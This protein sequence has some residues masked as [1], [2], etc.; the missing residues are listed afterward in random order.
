M[1]PKDLDRVMALAASLKDAPHWTRENYL[2]ALD[3]NAV[4][5]RI[6]LVSEE[7]G[8]VAGLAVAS[9]I[10]PQAELEIIAVDAQFQRRSLA[11]RLFEELASK[12]RM[13]G[14]S[15]LVLE[16]RASNQAALGFYRRLGFVETGRRP[17]YYQAPAEDA[18]LMRLGL[19][20]FES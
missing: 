13:A 20:G 11:R 9:L 10:P 2:A 6:A 18:V 5:R 15:E 17:C 14:V 16:V 3:S 19:E 8:K 7:S 1:S 4:P 12:L